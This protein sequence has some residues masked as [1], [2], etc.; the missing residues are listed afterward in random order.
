MEPTQ[1]ILLTD[2]LYILI[3]IGFTNIINLE[4]KKVG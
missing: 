3:K 2:E 1:P 4:K